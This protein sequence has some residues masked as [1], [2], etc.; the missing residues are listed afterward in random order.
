[1][2]KRLTR[3]TALLFVLGLTA[4]TT[5]NADGLPLP[6]FGDGIDPVI[7]VAGISEGATVNSTVAI[8]AAATDNVGVTAFTLSI[9]GTQVASA[10]NGALAYSWV[11]TGATNAA[12]TLVFTAS[13]AAGNSASTT[14]HATVNNTGGGGGG[15]TGTVSGTVFTPN[16]DDP[17]SGAI[18][19]VQDDGA[20]AVGNPPDEPY[21]VFTYSGANGQF[22]LDDVPTGLQSIKIQK[23]AFF[24]VFNITVAQGDN[25]VPVS[26]TTLPSTAAGGAGDM[27]VVTGHY[28]AIQNVLAKLGLGTSN[29]LSHM[30]ELGTETFD[31]VDG[32]SELPDTY[33]D[34]DQW[35]PVA[36]NWD[37]YRTIFLNCGN[38]YDEQFLADTTAVAK[39][40]A[41]VQAGGHLYCTDWSYNFIEQVWP[42]KVDF[43]DFFAGGDGLST[44]PED[45]NNAKTGDSITSLPLHIEDSGL[46]SWMDGI[47]ASTSGDMF[48][49]SDW[50]GAWVPMDAIAAGGVKVWA[51]GTP[52]GDVERPMTIT[53]QDGAGTVLYSSYHTEETPSEGLTP[54][55]RV[56]QYLI[57]EVL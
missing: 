24:K 42:D 47:S 9:D 2:V 50:L 37:K 45:L 39:L 44:T 25:P 13:D 10:A 56:L 43:D 51:K 16:G 29:D 28:D 1:M 57:F 12:H 31:M 8:S 22:T 52:P 32:D 21:V 49:T 4:C 6:G 36:A 54:Q 3:V 20:S 18:I 40:K 41:W 23:G 38:D 11:T 27:L 14:L 7:A 46:A 19:F 33:Q 35:W 30:L 53:F 15:D 5:G 48:T 55:E 17:V 34:F 26:D